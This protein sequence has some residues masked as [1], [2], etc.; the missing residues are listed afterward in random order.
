MYLIDLILGDEA[1]FPVGI[2]DLCSLLGDCDTIV[3][4]LIE[5]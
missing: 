4:N 2:G 1:S 3:I 5:S